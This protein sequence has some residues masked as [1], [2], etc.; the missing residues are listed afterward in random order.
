MNFHK[1]F[2]KLK[3]D[4]GLSFQTIAQLCDVSYQT[5]QQWSKDENEKGTLPRLEKLEALAGALKTTP[6][7]L[8]FGIHASGEAPIRGQLTPLSD[9]AEELIEC[10]RRLDKAGEVAR[11]TFTLHAGLLLLQLNEERAEDAQA[12]LDSEGLTKHS[13]QAL[14]DAERT[15]QE[16]VVS[17]GKTSRGKHA[18]T[19]R[20]DS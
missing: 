13:A 20:G 15:A 5:V 9:E 7:F 14:S 1:R 3:S 12:G 10:V 2:R 19:A 17:R 4:A 6:W 16:Q 18:G 11:K 8:L